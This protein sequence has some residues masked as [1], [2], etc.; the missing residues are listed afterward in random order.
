MIKILYGKKGIG[1]SRRLVELANKACIEQGEHCVFVDKDCDHMYE[2]NREIRFINASDYS[3]DGPK[4]FSGF[5][6]GIAAQDFDLQSLYINSFMK[7]V[8]H[9]LADLEEMIYFLES[10][11]ERMNVELCIS[12]NSDGVEG[13]MPEFIKKYVI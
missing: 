6:S 5:I 4:M 10:F 11:S 3:I 2:L 9:P 1:K 8:K 13:A 12:I 7:L